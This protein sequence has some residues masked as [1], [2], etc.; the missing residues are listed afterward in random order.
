[1]TQCGE[2][3]HKCRKDLTRCGVQ[4]PD[5]RT[6]QDI[7]SDCD[8]KSEKSLDKE[9]SPASN[10]DRTSS[11]RMQQNNDQPGETPSVDE[12]MDEGYPDQS[13]SGE[14]GTNVN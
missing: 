11:M 9:R 2:Q 13:T 6:E 10:L 7:L 14:S 8:G 12:C 4:T 1:M 5:I 3:T